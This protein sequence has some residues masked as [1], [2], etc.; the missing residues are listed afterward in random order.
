M[1]K[2]VIYTKAKLGKEEGQCIALAQAYVVDM[3]IKPTAYKKDKHSD[4]LVFA[5]RILLKDAEG[6]SLKPETVARLT[7]M[8]RDDNCGGNLAQFKP[9]AWPETKG[10]KDDEA[11][12]ITAEILTKYEL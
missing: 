12:E 10:Q 2:T 7:F 4:F 1:A 5:L 9:K 3:N 6:V 8:L 11:E